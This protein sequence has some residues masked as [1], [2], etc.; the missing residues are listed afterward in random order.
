MK[1]P[2][3]RRRRLDFINPI[4]RLI[5]VAT[6]VIDHPRW[7]QTHV[8][9]SIPLPITILRIWISYKLNLTLTDGPNGWYV[10][11]LGKELMIQRKS[12]DSSRWIIFETA[13]ELIWGAKPWNNWFIAQN[14]GFS[15][16]A[17]ISP[18]K[19]GIR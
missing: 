11:I 18:H 7:R 17:E 16:A 4:M 1:L 2:D 14:A 10:P 13:V 9:P 12:G 8:A 19:R 15:G 5:R 3:F 6:R